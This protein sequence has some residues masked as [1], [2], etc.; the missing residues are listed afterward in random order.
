MS[1][2][3]RLN[4]LLALAG[5]R[6]GAAVVDATVPFARMRSARV[7]LVHILDRRTALTAPAPGRFL[8]QAVDRFLRAG[9]EADVLERCASERGLGRD[10]AAVAHEIEGDVVVLGSD[11]SGDVRAMLH[12][13]VSHEVLA[14]TDRPVLLL[15]GPTRHFAPR[16]ILVAAAGGDEDRLE[17]AVALVALPE[18]ELTVLHVPEAA[19]VIDQ[20]WLEPGDQAVETAEAASERFRRRGFNA[21]PAVRWGPVAYAIVTTAAA[22]GCDM[23]ALGSRPPSDLVALL[24]GSVAQQ[25][26]QRSDRPVLL[27]A[28]SG[29]KRK[30]PAVLSR[31]V[32]TRPDRRVGEG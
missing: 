16:R 30:G 18:S 31:T 23:I 5:D 29:R 8:D 27:G 6:R 20:A 15:R 3:R 26:I 25:V 22:R 28:P 10:I 4:V 24:V 9:V 19:T 11:G 32:P 21:T 14:E 13:S 12:G 1:E 2:A 17:S 7:H